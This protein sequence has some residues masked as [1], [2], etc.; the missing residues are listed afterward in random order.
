MPGYLA[1]LQHRAKW[2]ALAQLRTG[3][4]WL[5]EETGRWQQQ[6][7]AERLCFCCAAAG[8]QHVEDV[9]H[10][11]LVCPRAAHLRARYPSLF[12]PAHTHSVHSFLSLPE[13]HLLASYCRALYCLHTTLT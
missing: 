10:A 1:A 5:A 11:V 9:E 12:T 3:S 4:H 6:P 7:R 13:P 8:E 2:R